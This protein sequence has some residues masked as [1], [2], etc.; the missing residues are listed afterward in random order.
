MTGTAGKW[1][2]GSEEANPCSEV[3]PGPAPRALG[4]LSAVGAHPL[5]AE[6]HWQLNSF[7]TRKRGGGALVLKNRNYPSHTSG[8]P[9][10]EQTSKPPENNKSWQGRREIGLLAMAGGHIKWHRHCGKQSGISSRNETGGHIKYHKHKTQQ[11]HVWGDT[12]K[13]GEQGLK[14]KFICPRSQ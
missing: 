11:F 4:G 12:Q 5:F 7:I 10:F 8:W 14:E 6:F 13:S 2:R 1:Q 9:L 3:P